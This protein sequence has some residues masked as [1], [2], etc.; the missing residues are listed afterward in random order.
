[1]LSVL[2]VFGRRRGGI[3]VLVCYFL[4]R[5][6]RFVGLSGLIRG[7]MGLVV[8]MGRIGMWLVMEGVGF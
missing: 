8:G 2:G 5:P 1:M 4:L 6:R 7:V 3:E